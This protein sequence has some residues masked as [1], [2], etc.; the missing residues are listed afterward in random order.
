MKKFGKLLSGVVI[1]VLTLVM[2]VAFAACGGSK[3]EKYT[4]A[5]EG[6]LRSWQYNF[7]NISEF[8]DEHWGM[9]NLE[10]WG[11]KKLALNADNNCIGTGCAWRV[12]LVVNEGEYKLYTIAHLTGNGTVYAGEGD[13]TYMFQGTCSAVSGGYKLEAPTYVEVSLS[14]GFNLI[15]EGPYDFANYIPSGPWKIDSTMSDDAEFVKSLNDSTAGTT[16]LNDKLWPSVLVP[17]VFGGATFKVSGDKITSVV[18][19]TLPM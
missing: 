12:E 18:D 1:A 6:A 11:N 7:V 19:V 13:Y 17:T 4:I 5:V 15:Y 10:D 16:G 8:G 9:I 3:E 2:S 14:E